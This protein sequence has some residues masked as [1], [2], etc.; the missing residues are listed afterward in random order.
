MAEK[1]Y[2]ELELDLDVYEN[3]DGIEV[4]WYESDDEFEIEEQEEEERGD[5]FEPPAETPEPKKHEPTQSDDLDDFF[6]SGES[7]SN[8]LDEMME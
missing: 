7:D 6:R 5:A 8:E 2:P 1:K 4:E 3:D